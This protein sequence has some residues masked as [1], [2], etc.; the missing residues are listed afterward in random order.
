MTLISGCRRTVRQFRSV[1]P[2]GDG[3]EGNPR[4]EIVQL[5]APDVP[6]VSCVDEVGEDLDARLSQVRVVG[7]C[8][9]MERVLA[10]TADQRRP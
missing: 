2:A 1:G 5:D 8:C 9:G 4:Q 10:S 6:V 7:H 3:Q